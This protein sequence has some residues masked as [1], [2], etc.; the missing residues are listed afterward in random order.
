MVFLS[1]F[2]SLLDSEELRFRVIIWL[3][4]GQLGISMGPA[5][6]VMNPLKADSPLA[7]VFEDSNHKK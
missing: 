1:F 6:S 2:I 5:Y 3:L 4:Q 7:T